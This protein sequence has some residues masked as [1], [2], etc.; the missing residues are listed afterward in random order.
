SYDEAVSYRN[1]EP[2]FAE[3]DDPAGER[4]EYPILSPAGE[5][6]LFRKMNYLKFRASQLSDLPNLNSEQ[7]TEREEYLEDA[8]AARDLISRSCYRLSRS[9]ARNLATNMSDFEEMFG[10]ANLILLK[11]IEKF[12][13]EKGFRFSTY[14]THSIQR[15]LFRWS[16]R[17]R[18]RS[19]ISHSEH[20]VLLQEMG[21]LDPEFTEST[22]TIEMAARQIFD[23]LGECLDEREELIIRQRFQLDEN[24]SPKTLTDLAEELG[25]SSERVRQIQMIALKKLQDFFRQVDQDTML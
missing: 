4:S 21:S 24:A 1:A 18:K 9:I 6:F 11:A 20:E 25:L 19:M 7:E 16:E 2:M 14:A 23:R 3:N 13:Y 5:R 12:D 17:S 22:L 15:H 8:R 10:E